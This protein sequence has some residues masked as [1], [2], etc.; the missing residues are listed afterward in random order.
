MGD[1][2]RQ[3]VEEKLVVVEMEEVEEKDRLM[4]GMSMLDFD[5]LC[6]TVASQTQGKWRKLETEDFDASG[7]SGGDF[8]GVFRMWEGEVFDC[9]DD[10]RIAIES[11]CCPCYR[12]GKN[13]RRGGFGSCFLQ[14][15][16]YCIL[17][18]S[19]LLNFIAFIITKRRCFLYLA[20]A[21]TISIG[22]YLGFFRTQMRKKFNIRGSD[23]SLDDCIYHIF[24][25]C[26]ALCQE[27]RTL[28][29]NNVQ[30]GI[31]HGRGDTICIERDELQAR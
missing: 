11:L 2:E 6:S 30:D 15:T 1:L 25:S 4:E 10:R 24:C 28:E 7:A 3:Q 22:M 18:L 19:S 26:C 13:M 23:N 16:V 14:G 27:T 17:A 5:M 31:W 20:V 12:F 8:G 21:F 29:M 9:C